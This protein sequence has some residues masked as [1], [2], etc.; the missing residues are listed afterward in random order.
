M[1]TV[2]DMDIS[3]QPLPPGVAVRGGVIAQFKLP[4]AQVAS[5]E[6]AVQHVPVK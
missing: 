6:L 5:D 1:N 3:F 4:D 2:F